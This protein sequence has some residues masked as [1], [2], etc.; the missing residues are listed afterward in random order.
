[1]SKVIVYGPQ[2][3][4]KSIK[5]KALAANDYPEHCILDEWDGMTPLPE[6]TIATSQAVPP[7]LIEH[8]VLIACCLP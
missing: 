4:G 7:F 8:D 3:S 5:A 6:N 2:G 1:M